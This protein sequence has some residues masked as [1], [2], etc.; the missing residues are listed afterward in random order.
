MISEKIKQELQ[1]AKQK[2]L[3]PLPADLEIETLEFFD[4]FGIMGGYTP[5]GSFELERST[6]STLEFIA[7]YVNGLLAYFLD[8]PG[9]NETVLFDRLQNLKNRGILDL[10]GG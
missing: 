7:V 1:S 4:Q 5:L 8:K 9:T 6:N 2:K 10:I 3:D